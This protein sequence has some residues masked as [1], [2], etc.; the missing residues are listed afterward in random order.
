[1]AVSSVAPAS[2]LRASSTL[3]LHLT[4]PSAAVT[5]QSTTGPV[6]A[7]LRRASGESRWLWPSRC[8][9]SGCGCFSRPE[10]FGGHRRTQRRRRSGCPAPRT[11][12]PWASSAFRRSMNRDGSIHRWSS[13]RRR[14]ERPEAPGDSFSARANRARRSPQSTEARNAAKPAMRSF[15]PSRC[16]RSGERSPPAHKSSQ[17]CSCDR[18]KRMAHSPWGSRVQWALYR[19]AVNLSIRFR[20]GET[21]HRRSTR[22][23]D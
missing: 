23:S 17:R 19:W 6:N 8:V 14:R 20:R 13:H 4:T 21:G 10:R 18:D 9:R 15:G 12:Q 2:C 22:H 7:C 11:C 3:L 1:M 16:H 5:E